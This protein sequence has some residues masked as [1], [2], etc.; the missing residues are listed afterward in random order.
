VRYGTVTE[1]ERPT[2]IAF[3]QPMTIKLHLGTVDV[4]MRYTL[5]P[6]ARSTR[7]ER[8]VTLGIP[9]SLKLVQPVLVHAF[10][11]ES[12]R[13]LLVLKGYADKLP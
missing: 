8:V 9:R 6:E 13:T 10:R 11:V 2:T 4:V 7:V 5:T 12:G 1:F 3:H